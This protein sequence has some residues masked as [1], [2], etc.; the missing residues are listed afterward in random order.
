MIGHLLEADEWVFS[1][2]CISPAGARVEV[3]KKPVYKCVV[4]PNRA[5]M[6]KAKDF[7]RISG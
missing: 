6:K 5:C 4:T 1:S 7:G 2:P 3:T